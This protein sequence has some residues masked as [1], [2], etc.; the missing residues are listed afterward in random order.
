[1][2]HLKKILMLALLLTPLS[3]FALDNTPPP[4]AD[5]FTQ[6]PPPAAGKMRKGEMKPMMSTEQKKQHLRKRQDYTLKMHALS[7]QILAEKD[8]VKAAKL[9]DTQLDL[10]LVHFEKMREHKQQM[11]HK[12]KEMKHQR[13]EMK[14]HKRDDK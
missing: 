4:P 9:K 14:K 13:K 11:K 10:M 6:P 8:P 5:N 7:S 2:K 3:G 1:M 12:R